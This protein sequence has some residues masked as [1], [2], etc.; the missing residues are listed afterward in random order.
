MARTVITPAAGVLNSSITSPAGVATDV[1]N[2]MVI[3]KARFRKLH[4]IVTNSAGSTP[5][6]TFRAGSYP[7]GSLQPQGDLVLSVPVGAVGIYVDRLDSARFQQN[8]GDLNIDFSAG[9]VGN[10]TVIQSAHS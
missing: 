10:I 7:V 1:A 9:F 4:F 5:T 8:N 2:G 3:N 6:I